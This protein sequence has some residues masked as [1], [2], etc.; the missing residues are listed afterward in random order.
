MKSK[1]IREEEES[2]SYL[3]A[4]PIALI[5]VV[6]VVE[7]SVPIA[8]VIILII[9]ILIINIIADDIGTFST[10]SIVLAVTLNRLF[11]V[12]IIFTRFVQSTS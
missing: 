5:V 1:S 2:N 9:I 7:G 10:I 3:P 6:V 11:R 4:T 12:V 8:T